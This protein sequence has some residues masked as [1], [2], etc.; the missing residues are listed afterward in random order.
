MRTCQGAL[1]PATHNH[2]PLSTH[3]F[4]NVEPPVAD[5]KAQ[6]LEAE[7]RAVGHT[8]VGQRLL[9]VRQGGRLGLPRCREREALAVGLKL[10]GVSVQSSG[11][12][13]K[14]KETRNKTQIKLSD[15]DS[16]S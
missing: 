10:G 3:I 14:K 11:K 13:I 5:L 1:P 2:W 4:P 8:V 15:F 6:I 9:V 7:L 16:S 12:T